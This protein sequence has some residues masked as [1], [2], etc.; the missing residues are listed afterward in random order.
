MTSV[1]V[2]K[3]TTAL[4]R[5]LLEFLM[6]LLLISITAKELLLDLSAAFDTIEHDKLLTCFGDYLGYNALKFIKPI[7]SVMMHSYK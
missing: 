6:I 5:H 7:L 3:Q 4:R 1:L 2:G